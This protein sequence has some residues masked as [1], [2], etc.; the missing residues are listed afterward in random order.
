MMAAW[1]PI[2]DDPEDQ[3]RF[4]ALAQGMPRPAVR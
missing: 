2:L 3:E 4:N 1:L